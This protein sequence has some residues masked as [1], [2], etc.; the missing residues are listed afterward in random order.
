MSTDLDAVARDLVTVTTR[1]DTDAADRLRAASRDDVALRSAAGEATGP[2]AV[3]DALAA[4]RGLFATGTW[5]EPRTSDGEVRVGATFPP[6]GFVAAAELTA[7]IDDDG[8]VAE[9]LQRF[10]LAGPPPPVPIDLEQFAPVVD[11][12]L[13]NGT[14]MIAAYVD[15]DGQPHLSFRGTVQ[16]LDRD[17]LAMWARDPDAGMPTTVPA[18]PRVAVW[19]HDP[20]TRT[21]LQFHGRAHVVDDAATREQVFDHS[22]EREQQQDPDRAGVAIVVDVDHVAGRTPDGVVHQRSDASGAS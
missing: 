21:T 22:P 17:H 6:G 11:G 19:Y 3:L 15:A 8:R 10:T 20:A 9:I 7:R 16:V 12:A 18:S 13:A 2:D 5:A 4:T 1:D 14:P